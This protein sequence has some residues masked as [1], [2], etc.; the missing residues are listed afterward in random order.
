MMLIVSE[1]QIPDFL[2]RGSFLCN[3]NLKKK[4]EANEI[5]I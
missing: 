4:K 1:P 3:S 5:E 2:E